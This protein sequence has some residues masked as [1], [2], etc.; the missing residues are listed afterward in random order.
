[1]LLSYLLSIVAIAVPSHCDNLQIIRPSDW[2]GVHSP[3]YI[4]FL[5]GHRIAQFLETKVNQTT[6]PG[7]GT[8][9]IEAMPPEALTDDYQSFQGEV[10]EPLVLVNAL[11]GIPHLATRHYLRFGVGGPNIEPLDLILKLNRATNPPR[12]ISV[13]LSTSSYAYSIKELVSH[14]SIGSIIVHFSCFHM[15][16]NSQWVERGSMDGV[17]ILKLLEAFLQ[18][19]DNPPPNWEL[20]VLGFSP[21]IAINT[22]KGPIYYNLNEFFGRQKR[23]VIA[24]PQ[25]FRKLI[26]VIIRTL[27]T[28]LENA[29]SKEESTDTGKSLRQRLKEY[30]HKIGNRDG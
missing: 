8:P 28:T 2:Y 20:W 15:F 30:W 27:A 11:V 1:M 7:Q 16:E 25:E 18:P 13:G 12:P 14:L 21:R 5:N 23:E 6:P 3:N 26:P 9:P 22:A 4:S 17:S 24:N 29:R 19:E 10:Q